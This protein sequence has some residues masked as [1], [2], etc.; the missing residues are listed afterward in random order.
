MPKMML[1][2]A[3]VSDQVVAIVARWTF[4]I[5]ELLPDAR[6]QSALPELQNV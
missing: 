2:M 3:V 4:R 1:V 6:T 5:S